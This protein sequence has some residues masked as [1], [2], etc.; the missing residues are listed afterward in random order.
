[1]SLRTRTCVKRDGH[2]RSSASPTV[3]PTARPIDPHPRHARPSSCRIIECNLDLTRS[4][5]SPDRCTIPVREVFAYCPSSATNRASLPKPSAKWIWRLVCA[6]PISIAAG[7]GWMMQTPPQEAK[8][9][10]AAWLEEAGVASWGDGFTQATDN[11]VLAG[12]I[13]SAVIF[14]IVLAAPWFRHGS[15]K[16]DKPKSANGFGDFDVPIRDAID[17]PYY[18]VPH[19]FNSSGKAERRFFPL[20]YEQMCEGNPPVVGAKGAGNAP[21]RIS[22]RQCRRLQPREVVIPKNPASPYGIRFNLIDESTM[23]EPLLEF[24]GPFGFSG[25]RVR[26][27][28]LYRIWPKNQQSEPAT[29]QGD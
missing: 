6:L 23:P 20:L 19:S 22:A 11:Y 27:R 10:A 9:N 25:L 5:C 4:P 12:C 17:H 8:S 24:S 16:A 2:D 29:T 28:D 3:E 18:T 13:T 15:G 14:L 21:K 1:M 7:V 26:S